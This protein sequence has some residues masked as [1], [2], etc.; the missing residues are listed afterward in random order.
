ME[1]GGGL[2]EAPLSGHSVAYL[3]GRRG[4]RD[5]DEEGVVLVGRGALDAQQG[6]AVEGPWCGNEGGP[7]CGGW[8]GGGGEEREC[9]EFVAGGFADD[10]L[11]IDVGYADV[12]GVGAAEDV[13]GD[14]V[15]EDEVDVVADDGAEHGDR[16]L[17]GET[18]GVVGDFDAVV[19]VGEHYRRGERDDG[20]VLAKCGAAFHFSGRCRQYLHIRSTGCWRPLLCLWDAAAAFAADWNV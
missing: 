4:A 20:H 8:G 3:G 16:F 6:E 7:D 9:D 14:D 12:E 15:G 17:G 11:D 5:V 10:E 18:H 2:A 13:G 19:V 1:K